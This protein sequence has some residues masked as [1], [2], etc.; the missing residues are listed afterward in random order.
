MA[1]LIG[2]SERSGHDAT[3]FR[4]VAHVDASDSW[5][6]RERPARRSVR[7]LLR[8]KN[9]DKVLLVEGRDDERMI[10]KPGFSHY[11][12]DFGFPSEVGNVQLAFADCF[13]VR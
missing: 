3:K 5:V 13:G 11:P 9:A 1:C 7:L 6:Q 4:N 10:C 8:T 2:V 12:V